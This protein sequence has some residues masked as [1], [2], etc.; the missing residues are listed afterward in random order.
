MVSNPERFA[1]GFSV[2]YKASEAEALED[3]HVLV[4]DTRTCKQVLRFQNS[5]VDH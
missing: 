2:E 1:L 3:V 4:D 5:D